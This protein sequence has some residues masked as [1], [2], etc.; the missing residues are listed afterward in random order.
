MTYQ[1]DYLKWLYEEGKDEKTIKAYK[2]STSQFLT[3]LNQTTG[4]EEMTDIKP[5]D[6]KEFISYLKHQLNRSQATVNK[7]IAALK[8]FFGYLS[9]QA[10]ISDNPMTRIKIQKVQQTQQSKG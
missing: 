7:S 5:I 9:E 2:T 6:V 4:K 10:Y 1:E 8:T 3:W